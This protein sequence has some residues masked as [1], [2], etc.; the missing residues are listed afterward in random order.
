MTYDSTCEYYSERGKNSLYLKVSKSQ[1]LFFL[2]LHCPK[3]EQNIGQN[4]A[5]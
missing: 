1:K 3:K 2:K 4:T 5:L